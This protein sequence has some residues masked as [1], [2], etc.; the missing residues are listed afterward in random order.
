MS[1]GPAVIIPALFWIGKELIS[2]FALSV[3]LEVCQFYWSFQRTS[4][5]SSHLTFSIFKF[6]V[7]YLQQNRYT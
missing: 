3:L 5:S 7:F 4:F 2:L 1:A 6:S